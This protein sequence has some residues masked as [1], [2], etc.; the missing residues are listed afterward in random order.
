MSDTINKREFVRHAGKYLIPG[1]SYILKGNPSITIRIE[2]SDTNTEGHVYF[3]QSG[4]NGHIKIGYTN[5]PIES[6]LAELQ[7]GNPEKLSIL[8][9]IKGGVYLE[10]EL[11]DKFK[12]YHLCYEW[13]KYSKDFLDEI[14]SLS[15]KKGSQMPSEGVSAGETAQKEPETAET[16]KTEVNKIKGKMPLCPPRDKNISV[17]KVANIGYVANNEDTT[18]NVAN[19]VSA[20]KQSIP[21]IKTAE[22]LASNKFAKDK[23]YRMTHYGC[24]C[25][26]T[27]ALMCP[28][29]NRG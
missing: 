7:T 1:E 15:D 18:P 3:I 6:R 29:H 12:R 10:R 9:V 26:K 14:H 23:E 17:P 28:K 5:R 8:K 4:V 11:Q 22:E 19:K 27:E 24:G 25:V 13:Y 20:I 2:L 16:Q 21:G